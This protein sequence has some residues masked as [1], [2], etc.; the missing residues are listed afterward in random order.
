MFDAEK[1]SPSERK[2]VW[3]GIVSG[4]ELTGTF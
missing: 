4:E 2:I 1:I 3:K